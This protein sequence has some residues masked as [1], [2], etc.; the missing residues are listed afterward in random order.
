M[1]ATTDEFAAIRRGV[2]TSLDGRT[3]GAA[4]RLA[5]FHA[6]WAADVEKAER[7]D[8]DREARADASLTECQ[9][10]VKLMEARGWDVYRMGDDN[11]AR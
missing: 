10:I 4:D 5:A 6:R 7:R 3:R 2:R 8:L 9:R 1:D 11:E